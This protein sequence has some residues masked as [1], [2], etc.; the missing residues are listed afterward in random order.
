MI[1]SIRAESIRLVSTPSFSRFLGAGVLAALFLTGGLILLGPDHMNPPMPG[2]ETSEGIYG[3]L[4]I[5]VLTAAIPVLMGS[6]SMTAEFAHRTIIPTALVQPRRHIIVLSKLLVMAI[7]GLAYG[8]LLSA[9]ALLGITL[10]SW[11]IGINPAVP[12]GELATA[13]LRIGLSMALYTII[14]V[15]LGA[16]IPKPQTALI[17]IIGW[18]YFAESMLSAI[19]G[20][21]HIYPWLP[22]GAA[23]AITGQNFVLDAITTT[24]GSDQIQLLTPTGGMLMLLGYALAAF[25]IALPTTLRKDIS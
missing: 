13:C 5:L 20:V 1:H 12:A 18:F 25:A 6:R 4:G 8:L 2:P 17:I 9:A 21:Q 15:G 14:G 22:G 3:L 24:T 19:P 23:S 10:G 16:L 11:A 7:A